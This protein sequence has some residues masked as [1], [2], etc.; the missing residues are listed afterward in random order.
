MGLDLFIFFINDVTQLTSTEVSNG[1][2][3][4]MKGLCIMFINAQ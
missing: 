2:Y 3:Y 1:M 4:Q